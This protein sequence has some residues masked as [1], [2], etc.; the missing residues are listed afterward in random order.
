MLA[1]GIGLK[2]PVN[3]AR[4]PFIENKACREEPGMACVVVNR[5]G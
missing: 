5:N 3:H 1:N 4:A 2:R